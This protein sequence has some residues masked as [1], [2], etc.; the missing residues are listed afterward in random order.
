MLF[1]GVST[2]ASLALQ[3]FPRWVE[4]IGQDATLEGVDIPV[5]APQEMYANVLRRIR[6]DSTVAGALVTTHKA[7]LFAHCADDFDDIA[8]TGRTLREIGAIF[9]IGN[10]LVGDATDPA[11]IEG[12]L[13]EILTDERWQ[14]GERRAL[15]LG[16]GGAG[17]AL[18][19]VLLTRAGTQA[20]HVTLTDVAP[21]R[22][23]TARS[24]LN[25]VAAESR[26]RVV[27][28]KGRAND[29][30]LSQLPAGSLIA[31][32]TGLG[33]DRPGSPLGA[34]ARF[35]A[36]G[37]VWEFNY[38]GPREFLRQASTQAG[39]RELRVSDGW[40]YF[41]SGWATAMS[42]VFDF[43]VVPAL[44]GSFLEVAREFRDR[45]PP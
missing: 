15:V 14:A 28:A 21:A 43:Q 19:Y 6:A 11:A 37:I 10:S 40:S 30:H 12:V 9:R 1:I 17:L 29:E 41:G 44:V 18:A 4:I 34:D 33:K 32:A 2:S 20:R 23:I 22:V 3:A 26:F 7:S 5:G 36:R 8:A 27:L 16:A 42:R 31:N 25:L 39:D 45:R 13:P 24:I 35:P 38:R